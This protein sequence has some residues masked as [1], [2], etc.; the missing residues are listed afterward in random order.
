MSNRVALLGVLL[1]DHTGSVQYLSCHVFYVNTIHTR[2]C[3]SI[4]VPCST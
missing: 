4:V 2:V 1:Y 3:G